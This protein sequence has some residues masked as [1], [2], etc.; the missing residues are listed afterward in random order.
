MPDSTSLLAF[1][2]AALVVLLIPGPGVMYVLARSLSQG[3]RAGLVSVL[4][5]SAGAF[6]HVIAATIGLSALLVASAAAFGIVKLL[7]AAYL[8]YLG[9][10]ALM[11]HQPSVDVEMPAPRSLRRL[12]T[13]GVIVSVLNPKVAVFFL[14][15]LP[16]FAD[17]SRGS[18]SVQMF[19]LGSLYCALAVFTDGTYALLAGRLR[20]WMRGPIA[21]GSLPRYA[22]G[23]VYIGLGVSTALVDQS[24]HS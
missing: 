20:H 16:H 15:F 7:G 18:V 21:R 1:V 6:V 13:D 19:V 4:G 23:A 14:A 17:P 22:S 9:I 10:R 5:L 3:Q 11:T 24:H 2:A 8:I 12:F